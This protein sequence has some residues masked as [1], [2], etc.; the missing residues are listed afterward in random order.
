MLDVIGAGATA[1]SEIDWHDVWKNSHEAKDLQTELNEV[2]EEGRKRPPVVATRRS[3]FSASW[4]YQ[5]RVLLERGFLSYWRNTTYLAAKIALNVL[6][7]LF[8]GFT[9]FK[10]KDTL[11]GSQ[12]KLFVSRFV[13]LMA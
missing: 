3:T 1:S 6:A 8:I 10:S 11:Q 12:N 7:G 9:F 5:L 13:S 4:S 2:N